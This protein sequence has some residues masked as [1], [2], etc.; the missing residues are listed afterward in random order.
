[1]VPVPEE[2]VVA[3]R[4]YLM[5]LDMRSIAGTP[6]VAL[7]PDALERMLSALNPD[8]RLALSILAAASSV[9]KHLTVAELASKAGWSEHATAGVVTE[10]IALVASAFGVMLTMLAGPKA[11]VEAGAIDWNERL[12]VVW[13]DLATAV[14]A[15]DVRE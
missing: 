13:K 4:T 15:V 6:G 7:D 11:D 9:D 10:L 8:G 1:M 5:G 14:V 2:L 12:V 3:T